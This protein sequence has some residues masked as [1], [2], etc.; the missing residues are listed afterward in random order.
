M[1]LRALKFLVGWL[2]KR[3]Q[4]VLQ[5][6]KKLLRAGPCYLLRA[7]EARSWE[8]DQAEIARVADRATR[9]K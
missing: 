4:L 2:L 7:L 8:Q 6:P 9:L 3:P 1:A 5:E